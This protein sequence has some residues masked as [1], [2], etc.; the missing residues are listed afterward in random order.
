MIA[1]RVLRKER[2]EHERCER[3]YGKS[4][5]VKEVNEWTREESVCMARL[6][7]GHSLELA[8][9]R[10]RIGLSR[11]GVCRR[12]GVGDETLEHVWECDAGWRMRQ[13]CGVSELSDACVRPR[14]ALRYWT[15]WRRVRLK[16][17]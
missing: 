10:Q 15:W 3:V 5:G 16:A 13:R 17:E 7:T 4:G 2:W 1:K 12:C 6:R 8:S 9:Y 11:S 14:D